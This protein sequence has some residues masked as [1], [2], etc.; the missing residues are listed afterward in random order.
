MSATTNLPKTAL[1]FHT[2]LPAGNSTMIFTYLVLLLI[3]NGIVKSVKFILCHFLY[4]EGE[5]AIVTCFRY[6]N[7]VNR[8]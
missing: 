5:A 6:L 7:G 8:K 1:T 4:F 3:P 2:C